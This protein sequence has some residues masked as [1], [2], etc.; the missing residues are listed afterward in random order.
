MSDAWGTLNPVYTTDIRSL[1]YRWNIGGD[2]FWGFSFFFSLLSYSDVWCCP[3]VEL[4]FA[5]LPTI[6]HFLFRLD[7]HN[8][9]LCM[10]HMYGALG[11]GLVSHFWREIASVR[12]LIPL[13]SRCFGM[14][15]QQIFSAALYPVSSGLSS[16]PIRSGMVGSRKSTI[17][18]A[19]YYIPSSAIWVHILSV[20]DHSC[21]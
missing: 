17:F 18:K 1:D 12:Q 5:R 21:F 3:C 7:A 11:V 20:E 4:A 10:N 14:G 6:Y 16:Q 13:G 2:F 15:V 9:P 19:E 8:T